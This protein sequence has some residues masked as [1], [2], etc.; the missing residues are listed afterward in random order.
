MSVAFRR[1]SDE[2][3]LEPKFEIPPPPGPNPVTARGYDLI[4]ARVTELEALLPT[5]VD[6]DARKATSRDLRYWRGRLA[7]A[8]LRPAPAGDKVEFGCRVHYRLNGKDHTIT[9]VGHD[10]ADPAQGLLSFLAPLSRAMLSG[11]PG[12]IMDFNGR[13]GVIEIIAI[14]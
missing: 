10:E 8:D 2:E 12:E 5:L 11:E 6:E 1:D 9:I 7:T 14:G 3:H 4:A 13:E